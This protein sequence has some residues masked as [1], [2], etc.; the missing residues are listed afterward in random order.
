IMRHYY[1]YGFSDFVICAGYRAWEIKEYFLTYEFRVN[2]VA[3]DHRAQPDQPAELF[4]RNDSQERWRVRIVDTGAETARGGRVARAFD[5]VVAPG[6]AS[7]FALT[8][9]DGLSDVSLADELAFHLRHGRMATVLGVP[10]LARFGELEVATDDRVT[11]FAEK[12][13]ARDS[14]I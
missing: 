9:G 13:Y 12:P 4:G 3:I 7:H 10:P 5:R 2:D 14:L 11:A 6:S 8:Y 1:R